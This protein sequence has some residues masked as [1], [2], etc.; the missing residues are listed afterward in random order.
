MRHVVLMNGFEPLTS[1][2]SDQHSTT[3]LHEYGWWKVM[4]SNHPSQKQQIY[5]LP[6]Y[7]LQY[8]LPCGADD[9]NRTYNLLITSQL[10]YRWATPAYLNGRNNKT[11]T[12]GLAV[13]S[14]ALYQTE[15]YSVM[16]I[17]LLHIIYG[18]I[19]KL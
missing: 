16:L 18:L 4:E 5:S 10:L 12:C 6:C 15:L 3:E 7:H 17:S 11:W 8:N 9:R 2:I 13:P 1:G 19:N 14:G